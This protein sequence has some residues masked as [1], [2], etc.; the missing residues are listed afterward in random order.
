MHELTEV[1]NFTFLKSTG[2]AIV[3]RK[4]I[5]EQSLHVCYYDNLMG[6]VLSY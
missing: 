3:L 1:Y 2:L 4:M 5:I 6:I